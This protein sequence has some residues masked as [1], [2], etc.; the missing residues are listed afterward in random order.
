M[1]SGGPMLISDTEIDGVLK[2]LYSNY[3]EKVFPISTPLL[4][5]VKK[6]GQGGPRSMRW[7]GRGVNFNVVMGRP[8]GM[9]ASASGYLPKHAQATEIQGTMGIKRVY[10]TREI[11]GLAFTGTQSKEA[12]YIA[13]SKK[14][15][16]EAK[17]A[18]QLGM[19]EFLHGDGRGIKAL[20]GS[21]TD[22]DTIVVTSPY[23]IAAA[24]QGG[25]LLAEGMYVA[26]LDTSAADAVLGKAI[27]T[28]VINA[29]DNA[30]L[31]LDTAIAGMAAGDKIVACTASDTGFNASP[32]GLT[33][34]LNRGGSFNVL[35]GIDAGTYPRW[36][37][38][39]LVAGTDT[40]DANQPTEKDIWQLMTLVAARSGK[41]AH[42]KPNEFMLL[43]TPGLRRTL[44]DVF[45]DSVRRTQA[46]GISIKGGFKAI[47]ICG[48]P[49]I[50]DGWCPA[51]CIYLVHLP[52]LTWVTGRDFGQ[53]QFEDSGKWRFIAGRDAYQINWGEYMEFGAVVRNSHGLITG[54]TDTVRYSHVV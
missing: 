35:H 49:L 40:P 47:E 32:T 25:L 16:D 34:I 12:A 28:S 46:E 31:E 52:S 14:I 24:G 23:G 17:D 13:L 1:P 39:R 22:T 43:T 19:Q 6:G 20:V 8:V 10:V 38:T 15:L 53:L 51:G 45:A 30:T 27:I 26:V 54:Y 41:D 5:N 3:R 29:G 33:K 11:D 37:T 21:V 48:L 9:T 44:A 36:N 4:A 2:T 50:A 18:A 7:G 42:M